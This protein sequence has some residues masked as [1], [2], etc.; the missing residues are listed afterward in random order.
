MAPLRSAGIQEYQIIAVWIDAQDRV[1]H[2]GSGGYHSQ[3][4]FRLRFLPKALSRISYW[5]DILE[6]LTQ[7][8]PNELQVNEDEDNTTGSGS[9]NGS[10]EDDGDVSSEETWYDSVSVQSIDATQATEQERAVTRTINPP[11]GF[12]DYVML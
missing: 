6:T 5:F 8:R 4:D 11:D 3:K 9:K 7:V 1:S 12:G 2:R 10:T